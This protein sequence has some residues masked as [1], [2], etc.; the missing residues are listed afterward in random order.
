L[1]EVADELE[2]LRERTRQLETALQTRI[3][4]EQAKGMLAARH[5]L[6]IQGA[7]DVLRRAARSSRVGI[8]DLAQRVVTEPE[9][10]AEILRCLR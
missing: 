7:F 5:G 1:A 3:V 4:I 2:V 8:H 10:P 9:T 6:G